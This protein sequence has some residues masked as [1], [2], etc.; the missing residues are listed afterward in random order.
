MSN[1]STY[2]DLFEYETLDRI[3]GQPSYESLHQ[4]RKQLQANAAS[5]PSTLGGGANGHLGLVLTPQQYAFISIRPFVRPLHPGVLNIAEGTTRDEAERLQFNH[6]M[7]TELFNTTHAVEKTL[8]QQLVKA[9]DSSYVEELR[10]QTTGLIDQPLHNVLSHLITHYGKVESGHYN[11]Q[12][13]ELINHKYDPERPIDEIFIKIVDFTNLADATK[14]PMTTKQALHIGCEIIRQCGVLPDALKKWNARPNEE[15]TWETFKTHFR[16]EHNEYRNTLPT[17][18][19][20]TQYSANMI[21]QQVAN[22][23]WQRAQEIEEPPPVE[24]YLP[25]AYQHPTGPPPGYFYP[26]VPPMV[27]PPVPDQQGMIHQANAVVHDSTLKALMD[28]FKQLNTTVQNLQLQQT[29]QQYF[30][31]QRNMVPPAGNIQQYPTTPVPPKKKRNKKYCW[32]HGMCNHDGFNCKFAAQGHNPYATRNNMMGGNDKG[33][34]RQTQ[35]NNGSPPGYQQ[36]QYPANYQ[37][38]PP[39]QQQRAPPPP[40]NYNRNM[41]HPTNPNFSPPPQQ[42]GAPYGYPPRYP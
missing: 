2:K 4:L 15:K 32:T 20:E 11:Q 24:P 8:L 27:P 13:V 42:G 37:Q 34:K 25:P 14:L 30:V 5:V 28:Q 12:Y 9:I 35:P 7:S 36:N 6:K 41:A 3:S 22:Q 40:A 38:A 23:L 29:N 19:K 33:L 1:T 26:P 18:A 39:Y 17:T 21:A 16:N 31:N 10:N